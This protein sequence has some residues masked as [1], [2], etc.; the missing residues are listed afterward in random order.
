[1]WRFQ[2]SRRVVEQLGSDGAARAVAGSVT[3]ADAQFQV[4]ELGLADRDYVAG[5]RFTM[6][7]IAVGVNVYRW[8]MLDVQR[9][10]L[11]RVESYHERLKQRP[12]FQ[13]HIMKPL[14]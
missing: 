14:T 12:A 10:R 7:D 8:S 6:G 1:L 11:P 3:G 9:P 4:L 5:E 2:S 13:K